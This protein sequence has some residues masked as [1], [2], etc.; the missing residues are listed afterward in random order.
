[1]LGKITLL[2]ECNAETTARSITGDPCAVHP[3]T[4][5]QQIEKLCLVDQCRIPV[6]VAAISAILCLRQ[7]AGS[8]ASFAGRAAHCARTHRRIT[9][10]QV[11]F[12][13]PNA[14]YPRRSRSSRT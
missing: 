14:S 7:D 13:Q 3:S 12:E 11:R 9:V 10:S 8:L 4:N 5:D 6:G 2:H 1:M